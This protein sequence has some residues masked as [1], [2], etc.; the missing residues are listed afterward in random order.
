LG[1]P[2]YE[3]VMKEIDLSN[4]KLQVKGGK[5]IA[6]AIAVSPSLTSTSLSSNDLT[7]VHETDYVKA[8]KV[9]G[10]SFNVGDTVVYQGREMVVSQGKN[11]AGN[12]KMKGLP[13]LAAINAIA[14]TLRVSGSRG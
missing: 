9:Q 7:A 6:E 5:A 3:N 13:D 2:T 10:S 12:I 8:R 14:D 11:K 1:R 4:N